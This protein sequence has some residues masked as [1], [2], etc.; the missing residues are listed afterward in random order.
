[1][2]QKMTISFALTL[3]CLVTNGQQ[4]ATAMQII[5]HKAE[6]QVLVC[7]HR[8]FHQTAPENSLA[9]IRLAIAAGIDLI[10]LD[11]RTTRDD[12]LVL[13]HD[14]TV[15]RTTTGQGR[16][17][18]MTYDEVSQLALTHRQQA[19]PQNVPTLRQALLLARGQEVI[20]NLD[21]KDV[22]TKAFYQQLQALDMQH[23]V[24][25]FIGNEKQI[26]EII[27]IDPAYA[28]LP[29]ARTEAQID[30]YHKLLQSPLIHLTKA[31]FTPG[32][33]AAVQKNKQCAFINT[34]WEEDEDL[35]TGDFASFDALLR[36]RPAIIQTDYPDRV[37]AH[38]Q[39][40]GWHR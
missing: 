23:R 9:S 13:M 34:L 27:A 20:L 11:V 24:I 33:L 6:T 39:A 22:D 37:L 18:E 2:I 14:A 26:R 17:R 28:V 3:A 40:L 16:V 4:T 19:N 25:S 21:L 7:A 36:Q 5:Q 32:C 30:H 38:L 8:S 12:S 35:A 1:M 31:S 15:D 10:E 29:L